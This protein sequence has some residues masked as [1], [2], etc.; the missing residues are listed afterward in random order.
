MSFRSLS[1]SRWNCKYHNVFIPKERKKGLYGKIRK[2]LGHVLYDLVR[3][4][5]SE[6]VEGHMVMT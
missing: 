2:F 4:R 1:Y 6:I 5:G 3:K